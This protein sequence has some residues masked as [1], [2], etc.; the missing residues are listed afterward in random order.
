MI[1]ITQKND[2]GKKKFNIV[3][4]VFIKKSK[5]TELYNE[6]KKDT[7]LKFTDGDY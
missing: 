3:I 2:S 4:S 7:L 5:T 1:E 6:T